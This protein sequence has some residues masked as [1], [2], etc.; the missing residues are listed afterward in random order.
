GTA[1][2]VS[3]SLG[4]AT[5]VSNDDNSGLT[6]GGNDITLSESG[7]VITGTAN[8]A[9]AFT[10]AVDSA[11]VVTLTQSQAIDH[12]VAQTYNDA[13][14]DSPEDLASLANGLIKLNATATAT[15]DSD[16]DSSSTATASLDLGGNIQFGDDGPGNPTLVVSGTEPIALTFDGGLT[17]GNF[18]GTDLADDTNGSPFIAA[19]DFSGAF[20]AGNLSDYGADGAG[21]ASTVSYSLALTG[22]TASGLTSGGNAITLSESGGVITGTA[23]GADAFTLAVDSAG[24]VTLTQF[25]AID[26]SQSNTY[27]GAY[28][29]DV[30]SL[31]NGLIELNA[32]ATATTDSDG[33]SSSTASASLDLGGNIQFGDDGPGNPTLVVSGTEPIALTFDGGLTDGNFTGT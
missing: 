3:Y 4:L 10:L 33:D 28:I 11:G 5:G 13:Y 7:G 23:G 2:T 8:G 22:P 27:N 26:H 32:T 1:S 16:G 29:D 6:S 19:V 17:D 18:T 9:D 25:Q 31:A 24:V 30:A 14:I 21:T 12:N 15:T 20:T